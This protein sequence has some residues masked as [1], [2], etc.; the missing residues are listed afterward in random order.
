MTR[1]EVLEKP[2]WLQAEA[3]K[4]NRQYSNFGKTLA[5]TAPLIMVEEN[6]I[7]DDN[8][9]FWG[10][11]EHSKD[12]SNE[13]IQSLIAKIIAGEYNNPG[14]YSMNTLQILKSLGKKELE[15]LQKFSACMVY[16]R[17]FFEDFFNFGEKQ[18]EIREQEGF[19][20]A[21]FVELQNLGL[22]QQNTISTKIIIEENKVKLIAYGNKIIGLK[23]KFNDENYMWPAS[24]QL[25]NSGK[26]IMQHLEMQYSDKFENWLKDF[27]RGKNF[28]I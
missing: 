20:Y 5:K 17:D 13:E 16:R 24:Y 12:I 19:G 3:A 4:M 27:F 25:S 6:K 26:Q 18:L 15:E 23:P 1:W 21:A 22:I 9:F 14:T 7:T 10:L 28:E 2:F 8:D 11:L